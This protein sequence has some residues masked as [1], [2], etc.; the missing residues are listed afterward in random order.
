VRLPTFSPALALLPLRLFLGATF[1]YAGIHKLSDPGFLHEGSPTY[2]GT[3]LEAFA[4]GTP[5]GVILRHLALPFPEVAGV[6][7][8]L[9][10]ITI[11]LLAFFGLFTR[12]AAAA[13]FGLSVFLFLTATWSTQPYF[14]GSDI[15][16]AFAWLPLLLAGAQ[17]Q[18]ALD[19]LGRR[20]LGLAWKRTLRGRV[21]APSVSLVE[22]L[23]RRSLLR[24]ALGLTGAATLGIAGG[25]LL[26]RGRYEASA[27]PRTSNPKPGA[28]V[29][30]GAS[31]DVPVGRALPYLD[32][33]D[34]TPCIAVR[35]ADGALAA[36]SA[37]CTHAA[38]EVAYRGDAL[39]CPCHG[40]TFDAATGEVL[41]GPPPTPLV[42]KQVE[43][44][45]GQIYQVPGSGAAN[46]A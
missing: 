12:L 1:V 29:R 21:P 34:G 3:Q 19:G 18:P 40:G 11:G 6:G 41:A 42:A 39:R 15:V 46:P 13:G 37:L 27:A 23:T 32:P 24:Q 20:G 10:E 25:S 35:N 2:I 38:C 30:I 17:G 33:G 9:V 31:A 44:R 36:F 14:L 16:F 7:V 43:E 28:G 22:G 45:D 8:A 26:V 4:E 5:G